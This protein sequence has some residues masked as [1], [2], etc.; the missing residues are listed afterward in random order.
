MQLT[1]A[2]AN[3][4]EGDIAGHLLEHFQGNKEVVHLESQA[5]LVAATYDLFVLAPN[6]RCNFLTINIVTHSPPLLR[7][8]FTIWQGTAQFSSSYETL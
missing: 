7:G 6:K 4:E 8:H 3:I 2:K 1:I 5:I